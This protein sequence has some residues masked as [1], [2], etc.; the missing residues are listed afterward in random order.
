MTA[1]LLIETHIPD[2]VAHIWQFSGQLGEVGPIL[3]DGC[4]DLIVSLKAAEVPHWFLTGLYDKPT[5]PE[6]HVVQQMIGFR[7]KPGVEIDAQALLASVRSLNS[8]DADCI[9]EKI[10]AHS[11]LD[12]RV[13]EAL[14]CIESV[15]APIANCARELGVQERTLQ[16]LLKSKTGRT[17]TYWRQL[18]RARKAGRQKLE[19]ADW[20]GFAYDTGF[21]DQAHM[22]RE[23]KR[24]FGTTPARFQQNAFFVDQVHSVAFG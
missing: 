23:F 2:V 19:G 13:N 3:P 12:A 20:A 16:R 18:A 17:P 14:S 10:A 11:K 6:Q 1:A 15:Q 8:F 9:N 21:S 4:Q 7:L 24:W 22:T 5:Q